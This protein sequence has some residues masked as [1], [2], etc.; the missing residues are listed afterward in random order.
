MSALSVMQHHLLNVF[1]LIFAIALTP[2]VFVFR[3]Y[4]QS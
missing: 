3:R 1:R 2:M 4:A